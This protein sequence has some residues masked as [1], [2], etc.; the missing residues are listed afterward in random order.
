MGRSG[1]RAGVQAAA[2]AL[3]LVATAAEGRKPPGAAEVRALV[4]A[5]A[6][7][8]AAKDADAAKAS[9]SADALV[10][11]PTSTKLAATPDEIV[12]GLDDSWFGRVD[13]PDRV[14]AKDVKIG[15]LG[16]DAAWVS[17]RLE[18][19]GTYEGAD[20]PV[21]KRYAYAVHMTALARKQGGAW[22]LAVAHYSEAIPGKR[23]VEHVAR[24]EVEA[25]APIPGGIPGGETDQA[26]AWLASPAELAAHLSRDPAT[27]LVGSSPG[28]KAVGA[29]RAGRMLGTWK[30]VKLAVSGPVRELRGEGWLVV[31]AHLDSPVHTGDGDVTGEDRA[32]VIFVGDPATGFAAAAA[33]YATPSVIF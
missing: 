7:A 10:W 4:T 28:E 16:A 20:A 5:H 11:L 30:K 31:A 15:G 6:R 23:A 24:R 8:L 12:R 26:A 32:L 21:G 19:G 33:H 17:A 13:G 27:V 25:L 18:M 14:V 22:K 1:F 29:A 3:V 2:V 9:F